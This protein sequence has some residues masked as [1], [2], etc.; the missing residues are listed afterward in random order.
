MKYPAAKQPRPKFIEIYPAFLKSIP[1]GYKR[2]NLKNS[3]HFSQDHDMKLIEGKK[4]V[5]SPLRHC[6]TTFYYGGVMLKFFKLFLMI[7]LY[8]IPCFAKDIYVA[9][10]G[11]DG[12]TG[13]DFAPYMT[14]KY[15]VSQSVSGDVVRVRAGIYEESWIEIREGTELVSE[16]GLYAAKIYSGGKSAI[17]LINNNSGLDGFE[18]YGDWNQGDAG[19]GL[20][21]LL[22]ADNLW[23]KNCKVHDAPHDCDVIKNGGNNVLIE[24]CIIYNPG[25]RSDGNY[26][27][28]LDIYGDPAP[29]GITVRG[30]WIYHTAERGG[31]FLIYAKGGT[32]NILWE[33]NVFGPSSGGGWGNVATGCGGASPA[34]FPACE[35]FI[36]RNNIFVNCAGD[37]A[38]GFTGSKNAYVY[39]NVFYNYTGNKCMIQFYTTQPAG[40]DRNEDCYVFNN[41]F[42]QSNGKPVYLDRGRWSNGE[43]TYI[44]ENFQS[45][46]NI[47]Y[48]VETSAL[49]ND[50]DIFS[51]THS[52]FSNPEMANPTMPDI[53]SDTWNSIIL[54]FLLHTSSPG[55]DA[56]KNLLSDATYNVPFDI[57]GTPRPVDG[58]FDIGIHENRSVVY[59]SK[60][61]ACGGNNPCHTTIQEAINVAATGSVIKIAQGIYSESI[62]QS[63]SKSVSIQGGWDPSFAT[64]TSNT[65]FIK[66]IRVIQGSFTLQMVTIKP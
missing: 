48:Q 40:M 31:D 29:D 10:T 54:N 62:T 5:A 26:Q 47:Y 2:Y 16:D 32:K 25:H 22:H 7:F 65:T 64:Q 42:M 18:I 19:D 60:E 11:N 52:L 13:D 6:S 8:A 44:P 58:V 38:F 35:N 21:R 17:R 66:V 4:V 63:E 46:Y 37:G 30:S 53:S 49:D 27:E 23:V 57:L 15:A 20:I 33:N 24:N 34:V 9:T 41:I 28:C 45:D 3:L 56:G 50:I 36:A 14:I 55:I 39:N 61:A 43:Y 59:V 51:E 1:L 12:S